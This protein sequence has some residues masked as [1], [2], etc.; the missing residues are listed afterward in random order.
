MAVEPPSAR[1]G[2]LKPLSEQVVVI[3]GASSGI[4][5][6]TA[7]QMARRGA[8]L[9]LA[10]RDGEALSSLAEAVNSE[11]GEGVAVTIGFRTQ[12]S[13]QNDE[14]ADNLE[15][16]LPGWGRSEGSFSRGAW[17][18]SAYNWLETRVSLRRLAPPVLRPPL[19]R[20]RAEPSVGSPV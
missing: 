17:S 9:A 3:M 8:R 13:D 12:L 7:L 4:G 10:A 20:D 19:L 18:H 15:T 6:E 16:P 5:R 11:G 1:I 14:G 2:K